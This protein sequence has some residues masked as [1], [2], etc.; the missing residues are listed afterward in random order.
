[1]TTRNRANDDEISKYSIKQ[2]HKDADN[3]QKYIDSLSD[4]QLELLLTIIVDQYSNMNLSYILD[5]ALDTAL[6][7][8]LSQLWLFRKTNQLGE[9]Q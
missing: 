6:K 1:M 3:F 4:I 5:A 9:P 7:E 8:E 2:E